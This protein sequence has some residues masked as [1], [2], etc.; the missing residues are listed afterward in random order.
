[1]N[2]N[3]HWLTVPEWR[4]VRQIDVFH[5][6]RDT[7]PLPETGAPQN[8]HILARG[9]VILPPG[10]WMLR[11]SADDYYHAWLDGDWMGQGPA[12]SVPEA[13]CYQEYPV[14]GGRA[15]TLA[16]HLYY[17]GLINRVWN[18]GDGRFGMCA[19]FY[20][21][22]RE[23]V[24]SGWRY[25]VCR[26]YSGEPTGYDTQFL[27]NFDSRAWPE[28]WEA[29]AFDDSGWEFLVSAPFGYR[30]ERQGTAPL[31][32]YRV[33]PV[34]V[35]RLPE[36]LLLDFGRELTGTLDAAACGQAGARIVLRFG[37]EL[38]GA[39]RVRCELRCNC[40]YE[41]VWT[42]AEGE[43]RL[44]PFDYKAFR[45]AE[46]LFDGTTEVSGLAAWVRH[47]PLDEAACTLD[48][49]AGELGSIFTICKNAVRC[50]MQEG[51]LDCPTRE[52][53]QYLGDAIITARSRVWLTGSTEMLRKCIRD[54]MRSR[55]T[56]PG[57]LGGRARFPDAGN[58]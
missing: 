38:D 50:G 15:V 4:N 48:C 3:A 51:Y 49:E 31:V 36:G 42:L 6:E 41:E 30:M 25:H 5:R 1:M 27:E 32:R 19:A 8:L 47:Y 43:N 10:Q 58:C 57:L 54:F 45:Y 11:L 17:Q 18:S 34:S 26:A 14:E 22:G 40:R 56:A 20:Q 39:G 33:E 2:W 24:P 29:P 53:G 28:G 44:H 35:Q 23:L 55:K 13:Y 52:K 7:R 46:I 16:L 21:G 9:R 37:E 12:P